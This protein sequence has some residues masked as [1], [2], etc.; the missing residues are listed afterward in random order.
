MNRHSWSPPSDEHYDCVRCENDRNNI[1]GNQRR[2]NIFGYI[3]RTL[4][5]TKNQLILNL[6][7]GNDYFVRV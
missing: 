6:T 3:R 1:N 4:M 7:K 5:K 2:K